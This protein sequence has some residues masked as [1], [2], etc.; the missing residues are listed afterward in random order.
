[1][2]K[3]HSP[4]IFLQDILSLSRED[5][6]DLLQ[7]ESWWIESG[8]AISR[9]VDK[10]GTPWLKMFDE[11][12]KRI[13]R[14]LYPAEYWT[15]LKKGYE[16][17]HVWRVFEKKSLYPFF[18]FGYITSFFDPG[19]Y[20]PYTVSLSTA[21]A[22]AKYGKGEL[23]TRAFQEL[24]RQH[25]PSQGATWM[26]EIR[27]GSDLGYAVETRAFHVENRN[28]TLTGEKY[29]ASNAGAEWALVAARPE[30]RPQNVRG[31][32]LFLVPRFRDD[33]SLNYRIRR[34]KDKIGT[35][36]V[37]TGEV[38]LDQS[39]A[40]L[41][42][43]EEQG[44][45]LILEVLNISRVANSVASLAVAHRALSDAFTFAQH[46]IAFG[47]P[48]LEH[49]LLR[50]QFRDFRELLLDAHALTWATVAH[51][52]KVWNEHPPYSQ[53]YFVFRLLA[54]LAK[55][56][57]AELAVNIT[58]WA[59]EVYGGLGVLEEMNIE[60]WLREALIL[61]IWEGTSHRQI[62]DGIEVMNKKHAHV[63]LLQNLEKYAPHQ[64]IQQWHEQWQAFFDLPEPVQEE[65]S[66][67]VFRTF[68]Q[69]VARVF[70][71]THVS[72]SPHPEATPPS[73]PF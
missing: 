33:G 31:L 39:H 54:H 38:V 23:A 28:Y 73:R 8:E 2:K 27:G 43:D 53:T 49:P 7:Y 63:L 10:H 56:W 11:T 42:G 26:T 9:S 21:I 57:T 19:L 34:L 32:A 55:F 36:S 16:A 69:W 44:I 70:R 24:T 4:T 18:H 48:I 67:F 50:R 22:I 64:E 47:K 45:Y 66:E 71:K 61:P 62:L 35:R 13:D 14:I 6:D 51:L 15:M 20:C 65:Q 46:R 30:G 68:A 1:M 52:E 29:F 41:L 37:P 5:A 72:S 25:N 60:R 40:L 17:G 12:G 3:I 59:I 58:R